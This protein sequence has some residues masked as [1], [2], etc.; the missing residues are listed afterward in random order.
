MDTKRG[1]LIARRYKRKTTILNKVLE[2]QITPISTGIAISSNQGHG[3][4]IPQKI[5]F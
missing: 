4:P 2:T 3:T 1:F 5:G